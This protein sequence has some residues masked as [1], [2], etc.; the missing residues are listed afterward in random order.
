MQQDKEKENNDDQISDNCFSNKNINKNMRNTCKPKNAS[1]SILDFNSPER[2]EKES[3]EKSYLNFNSAQE[4]DEILSDDNSLKNNN[5][6]DIKKT[7][8]GLVGFQFLNNYQNFKDKDK[9]KNITTKVCFENAN[10]E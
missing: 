7:K 5:I 9:G 2:I 1:S 10:N 8:S 4:N 3:K 6:K